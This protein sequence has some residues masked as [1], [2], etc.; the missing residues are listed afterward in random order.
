[1]TPAIAITIKTTISMK[2]EASGIK[3]IN[4]CAGV[5]I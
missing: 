1:M 3:T 5:L 2:D 4:E